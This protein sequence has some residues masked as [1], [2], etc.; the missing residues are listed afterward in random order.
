MVLGRVYP[1]EFPQNYSSAV[2][3][4]PGLEIAKGNVYRHE[5]MLKFGRNPD[6]DA[7]VE[8]TIWEAGGTYTFDAS[9]VA[10]EI[11]SASGDDAA[12]GTGARTVTIRGLDANWNQ[13]TVTV[14]LN[15]VTPV[16]IGTW[17][18]VHRA[19]VATAG[20]GLVNAGLLTVRTVTGS[21]TRLV[22][23][24]GNGQTLMAV[25]TIPAG[26]TGY[27]IDYYASANAV[28]AAYLDVKLWTKDA[29]G[30]INLKHQ[31]STT[32]FVDYHFG[33]PFKIPEKNDIYL[34][35]VSSANNTDVCGG[36]NIVLVRS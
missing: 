33:A 12:G 27:L 3:A 35:A 23:G 29:N 15:G 20:S 4:I 11:L 8:E 10:M 26:F 16:A 14:T 32:G 19:Q 18:R 31:Q 6:I 1:D 13:S 30:I 25:Y 9:A 7:N 21:S 36:F 2:D 34:N 5:L 22:I 28:A 24:A 17:L